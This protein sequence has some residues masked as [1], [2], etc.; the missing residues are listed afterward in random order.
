MN[1]VRIVENSG[2]RSLN[3]DLSFHPH[4]GYR[5]GD[6]ELRSAGGYRCGPHD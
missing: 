1:G 5:G 2:A 6:G 4:S 3:A